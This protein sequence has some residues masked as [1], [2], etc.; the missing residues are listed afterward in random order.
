M[1][2]SRAS[3]LTLFRWRDDS[4]SIDFITGAEPHGA[5]ATLER[6]SL[7]GARSV[8]RK[9]PWVPQGP[10]GTTGGYRLLSDSLV[11][12]GKDYTEAPG[13]SSFLTIVDIRTGATR[14]Y[15]S[16]FAYW[17][18][19]RATATELSP[20]G[21]WLAFGSGGQ[22]DNKTIP[23]WAITSLDGKTVRL[24]GE[25]MACDAWPIQWL[26][27]SRALIAVGVSS[28]DPF[29]ADVYVVPIDGSPA[30][31]LGVSPL[32]AGFALTSDGRSLLVGE[33]GRSPTSI[34]ALNLSKALAGAARTSGKN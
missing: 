17:Q 32:N 34:V 2:P 23:Q 6:V 30:R 20:D 19:F 5:A 29:N 31:R 4:R 18:L 12:L 22:K 1:G 25:P 9:L 8:I 21:K 26:P 13:D 24:L 7:T 15:L 11:A 28:C 3:N 33:Y 14:A 16:R 10:N 27:D